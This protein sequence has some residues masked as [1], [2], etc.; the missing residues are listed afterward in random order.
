V[1]PLTF[2]EIDS[3]HPHAD[4]EALAPMSACQTT[5]SPVFGR[6]RDVG[7][8]RFHRLSLS[9][10]APTAARLARDWPIG[11]S[12][13][14]W[15]GGGAMR[16]RI[17]PALVA[18]LA[19]TACT[20]LTTPSQRCPG[21]LSCSQAKVCCPVGYPIQCGGHCYAR[22]VDA[23]ADGCAVGLETCQPEPE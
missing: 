11:S 4:G 2:A 5:V 16:T 14:T 22:Q 9:G 17:L 13:E 1:W 3:R 19:L 7:E 6:G 23:F 15:P 21:K 12:V 8:H 10:G 18:L 20:G